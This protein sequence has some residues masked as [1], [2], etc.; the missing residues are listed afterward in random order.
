MKM[1]AAPHP[2]AAVSADAAGMVRRV[3]VVDD[4]EPFRA[5]VRGLLSGSRYDVIGEAA[6][7]RSAL[8]ECGRLQP[9]VV[10]LDVQ[11]PDLDGFE[12]AVVLAGISHADVVLTSTREPMAY[13]RR[14]AQSP[15]CGFVHKPDLSPAALDAVLGGRD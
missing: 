12:V 13:R 3:L 6:D 1:G 14:L 15:A 11:L 10:L 8:A 4:H 7:G 9:D 5:A 2:I